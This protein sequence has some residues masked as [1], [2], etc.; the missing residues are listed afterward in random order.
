MVWKA[1]GTLGDTLTCPPRYCLGERG[2]PISPH[3]GS[4][5]YCYFMARSKVGRHGSKVLHIDDA[6][7]TRIQVRG[8]LYRDYGGKRHSRELPFYTLLNIG[9]DRFPD[10]QF[11]VSA[12]CVLYIPPYT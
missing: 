10:V 12:K 9:T 3:E 6:D 2:M 5:C 11:S 8:Q 1:K 7:R 4:I